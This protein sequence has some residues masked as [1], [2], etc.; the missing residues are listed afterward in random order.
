MSKEVARAC[1][2]TGSGRDALRDTKGGIEKHTGSSQRAARSPFRNKSLKR[3]FILFAWVASCGWVR[4]Q[5]ATY[6][7]ERISC[8]GVTL[9]L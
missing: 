8:A 7:C 6:V 5:D 9:S 4:S 3:H 2:G 1:R